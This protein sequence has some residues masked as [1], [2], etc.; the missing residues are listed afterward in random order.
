MLNEYKSYYSTVSV[1]SYLIFNDFSEQSFVH[2]INSLFIYTFSIK[3]KKKNFFFVFNYF[4]IFLFLFFFL[5][6]ITYKSLFVI[7]NKLN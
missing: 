4:I 5:F 7:Y 3:I 1:I 2:F 6:Y